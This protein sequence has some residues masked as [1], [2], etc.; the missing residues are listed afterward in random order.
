M[1]AQDRRKDVEDVFDSS[2]P[3][4]A[5]DKIY[6]QQQV[7]IPDITPTPS[8]RQQLNEAKAKVNQ[9]DKK[10]DRSIVQVD[11]GLFE[12]GKTGLILSDLGADFDSLR[13]KGKKISKDDLIFLGTVLISMN[14]RSQMWIGDCLNALE[15]DHGYTYQQFADQLEVPVSSLYNYKHVMQQVPFARRRANLTYSHYQ[16][17]ANQVEKKRW[18]WIDAASFGDGEMMRKD[19]ALVKTPDGK[20]YMRI[21]WSV[22]KLRE[23]IAESNAP[24]IVVDFLPLVQQEQR[25]K[26]D[27]CL[28][29]IK[30][31]EEE[32]TD[33]MIK[34]FQS[35]SSQV[36]R[37]LKHIQKDQRKQGDSEV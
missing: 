16:T 22:G 5:T 29:P 31:P 24:A 26:I 32:V 36:V 20:D 2:N 21:P 11:A 6:S 18:E 15:I 7:D 37:A 14:E 12:F 4:E 35:W 3:Q 19:G 34:E 10:V 9:L 25:R 28:R 33:S 1:N 13:A 8:T 17:V 23:K 27:A 30:K